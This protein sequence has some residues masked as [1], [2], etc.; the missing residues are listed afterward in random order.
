M[1]VMLCTFTCSSV[2]NFNIYPA[3]EFHGDEINNLVS[4][5]YTHH[6]FCAGDL[7]VHVI[8][9]PNVI[10]AETWGDTDYPHEVLKVLAQVAWSVWPPLLAVDKQPPM[11]RCVAQNQTSAPPQ[12]LVQG[13]AQDERQH[14]GVCSGASRS[15]VFLVRYSEHISCAACVPGEPVPIAELMA[16]SIH[17][18]RT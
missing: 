5:T 15:R 10:K 8:I 9:I 2:I 4:R 17:G 11:V 6:I 16:A 13:V 7:S 3:S 14:H 1:G 12:V 18:A